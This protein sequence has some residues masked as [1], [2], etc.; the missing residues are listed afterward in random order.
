MTSIFNIVKY[1][2][3]ILEGKSHPQLLILSDGYEYVVKFKRD[4]NGVS[5]HTT[6]SL[7]NEWLAYQLGNA[8][9]LPVVPSQTVYIP[10]S[11]IDNNQELSRRRFLPGHQ[12][13]SLFLRDPIQLRKDVPPPNKMKIKNRID[14]AGVIV[15][16]HWIRNADRARGNILLEPLKDGTYHF[17]MIDHGDCFPGKFQ[18]TKESLQ[19]HPQPLS[20]KAA[21]RWLFSLLNHKDEL[22]SFIDKINN[23]SDEILFQIIEDIPEDWNVDK[24]EKA[25]LF[26]YLSSGKNALPEL[27]AGFLGQYL[28]SNR[29][30]K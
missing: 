20:H 13:A 8:L 25:A 30:L 16:D 24:E 29:K 19:E 14:A 9:S 3:P 2:K 4:Y 7:V 22:Y 15:F 6:R 23:L 10:N 11:F 1:V 17:H 18:W 28:N 21:Y 5:R 26:Q 12:F 27:I